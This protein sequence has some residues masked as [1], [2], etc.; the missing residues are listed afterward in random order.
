MVKSVL[1]YL[2]ACAYM[3][4]NRATLIN[5]VTDSSTQEP[6]CNAQFHFHKVK[7]YTKPSCGGRC[8]RHGR[9]QLQEAELGRD[10]K[11]RLSLNFIL[12]L[13]LHGGFANSHR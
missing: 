9:L 8:Q 3:C 12:C 6:R 2:C 13:G 10:S 11:E 4:K 5:L 7:E 1:T